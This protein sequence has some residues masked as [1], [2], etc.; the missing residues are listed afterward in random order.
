MLAE[1]KWPLALLNKP[2]TTWV[3]LDEGNLILRAEQDCPSI[4]GVALKPITLLK[5]IIC[6]PARRNVVLGQSF[7]ETVL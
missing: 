6:L 7:A 2:T 5:D 4:S 3:T 1:W